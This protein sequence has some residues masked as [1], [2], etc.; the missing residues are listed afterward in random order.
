MWVAGRTLRWVCG[1][2]GDSASLT[3]YAGWSLNNR[4]ALAQAEGDLDLAWQLYTQAT[5]ALERDASQRASPTD[6]R[7]LAAASL[8]LAGL[9]RVRADDDEARRRLTYARRLLADR[10]EPADD[11]VWAVLIVNEA[12]LCRTRGDYVGAAQHLADAVA[13]RERAFGRDH[14]DTGRAL[15]A[16]GDALSQ[17]GRSGQA[18]QCFMQALQIFDGAGAD[19][20]NRRQAALRALDRHHARHGEATARTAVQPAAPPGRHA[21]L[22]DVLLL[23]ID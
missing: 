13:M 20:S 14:V 15:A 16:L 19:A 7:S 17:S 6:R 1:I 21:D 18:E 10:H 5:T 2:S 4:G 12:A 3:S 23:P 22:L 9:A 8:N 11:G